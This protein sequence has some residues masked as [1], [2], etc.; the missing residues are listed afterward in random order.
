MDAAARRRT[1]DGPMDS[2]LLRLC[3]PGT[4]RDGG[5]CPHPA[6]GD[7]LSERAIAGV[8]RRR[9]GGSPTRSVPGTYGDGSAYSLRQPAYSFA[10][11][12]FGPLGDGVLISPR[13][14]PQMIGLGLLEAVPDATLLALADPDDSDG[15]GISGR[16]NLVWDERRAARALGRFGWKANVPTLAQQNAGAVSA[17]SASP[18]R[19]ARAELHAPHSAPALAALERRRRR[20]STGRVLDKLTFYTRPSPCPRAARRARPAVQRGERAVRAIGCAA[21]HMPT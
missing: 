1:A 10:D 20:R 11:L 2:M 15:D 7:Q 17:T 14:A 6:Y 8:T 19:S 18:R 21:C 16:V 13:V 3:V 9:P 4:E 12:A 5:P